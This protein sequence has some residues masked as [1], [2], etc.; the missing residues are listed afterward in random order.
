MDMCFLTKP[1]VC[2]WLTVSCT[3]GKK[4]GC[5]VFC[6]LLRA[7]GIHIHSGFS[8]T[9]EQASAA[10]A[11]TPRLALLMESASWLPGDI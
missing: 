2:I 10:S 5:S 7:L 11:H 6:L 4:N 1:E 9:Q 3:D 8:N